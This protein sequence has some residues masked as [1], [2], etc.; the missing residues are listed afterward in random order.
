[1]TSK[2]SSL[3]TASGLALAL[4]LSSTSCGEGVY[5]F[6][7]INDEPA[8]IRI[9]GD[10]KDQTPSNATRDVVVFVFTNITSSALAAGPPYDKYPLDGG[11]SVDTSATPNYDDQESR[12]LDNAGAFSIP[13]VEH[14][15]ITI[16]FLLD[17]PDPDG[18]IHLGD[19]YAVFS[20]TEG[21]LRGVK[22]GRTVDIPEIEIIYDT[23]LNGGTALTDEDITTVIENDDG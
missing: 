1:M 3:A 23:D 9:K 22:G 20:E 19:D 12:L 2:A 6:G 4:L 8:S 14:G 11:G 13:D 18:E 10:V 21:K 16:M 7:G 5:I 15:D 17:D